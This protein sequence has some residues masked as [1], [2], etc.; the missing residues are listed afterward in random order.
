MTVNDRGL[1]MFIIGVSSAN[2][3]KSLLPPIKNIRQV[4]V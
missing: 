4:K 3:V 2:L 1:V